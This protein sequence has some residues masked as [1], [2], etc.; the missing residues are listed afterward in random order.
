MSF[1][2]VC[3]IGDASP[4]KVHDARV[5]VCIQDCSPSY[6]ATSPKSFT[7]VVRAGGVPP[8]WGQGWHRVGGCCG[9]EVMLDVWGLPLGRKLAPVSPGVLWA[10]VG[11]CWLCF[12]T[13]V[14]AVLLAPSSRDTVPYC[15]P[16]GPSP[17]WQA[18]SLSPA[19]GCFES[20]VL[21]PVLEPLGL[22]LSLG[23]RPPSPE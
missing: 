20:G 10:G 7:F 16:M 22:F 1:R 6:R 12:S 5:E 9:M 21:D 18:V 23:R 14:P 17:L 11:L 4:S 19:R 15:C 13:A 3:E 8:C 2:I